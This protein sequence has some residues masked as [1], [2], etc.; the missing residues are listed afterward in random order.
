[1]WS[2]IYYEFVLYRDFAPFSLQ[3][4]NANIVTVTINSVEFVE[5]H[6]VFNDF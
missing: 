2:P 1:M 3:F 4:I 6:V 5:V